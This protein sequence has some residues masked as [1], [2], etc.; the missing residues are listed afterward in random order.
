MFVLEEFAWLLGKHS[1][2]AE[3]G[4]AS[5]GDTETSEIREDGAVWKLERSREFL[6]CQQVPDGNS[7][8]NGR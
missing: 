1:R 6:I 7:S 3:E 8:K 4:E 5:F 2:S